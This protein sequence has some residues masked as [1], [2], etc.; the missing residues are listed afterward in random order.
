MSSQAGISKNMHIKRI[1]S[2]PGLASTLMLLLLGFNQI[3]A[4]D[5]APYPGTGAPM[6]AA[7]QVSP[8]GDPTNPFSYPFLVDIAKSLARNGFP[9]S[10]FLGA[11]SNRAPGI[12]LRTILLFETGILKSPVK[13]FVQ[14][15]Q[16]RDP[17]FPSLSVDSIPESTGGMPGGAIRTHNENREPKGDEKNGLSL[18]LGKFAVEAGG[19][20]RLNGDKP[21]KIS[22]GLGDIAMVLPITVDMRNTTSA[23]ADLF[24]FWTVPQAIAS[25]KSSTANA[26]H[27]GS[28]VMMSP[29]GLKSVEGR[30]FSLLKG[31]MLAYSQGKAIVV[32]TP[33]AQ[34]SVDGGA[35]AYVQVVNPGCTRVRVLSSKDGEQGVIVKTKSNGKTEELKLSADEDLVITDHNL[36]DIDKALQSKTGTTSGGINW[37]KSTFSAKSL[38]EADSFFST[39]SANQNAE[40]KQALL[41]LKKQI[42]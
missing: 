35:S 42:K 18:N 41:W 39:D 26:Y 40:Q 23:P 1:L 4:V 12:D 37:S 38:F 22:D 6:S 21:S 24:R 29:T 7:R 20:S 15:K 25:P 33:A 31:H 34:V 16:K 19:N 9:A 5:A 10:F 28:F 13:F 14:R 8:E 2:G 3:P 32:E 36:N 27:E 30:K 11:D 17:S